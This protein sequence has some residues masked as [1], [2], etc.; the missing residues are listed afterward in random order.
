MLG[1]FAFLSNGESNKINHAGKLFTQ[2]SNTIIINQEKH[3]SI[4][5]KWQTCYCM[6]SQQM[7]VLLFRELSNMSLCSAW[8]VERKHALHMLPRPQGCTIKGA[9]TGGP[10]TASHQS[11]HLPSFAPRATQQLPPLN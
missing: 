8:N 1:F 7:E 2:I 4:H 11:S 10:P 5:V 3:I 9:R 6:S